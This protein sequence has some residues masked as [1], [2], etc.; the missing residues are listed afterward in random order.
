MYFEILVQIRS[1]TGEALKCLYTILLMAVYWM[2]EALPLPITSMI[3]MVRKSRCKGRLLHLFL[4]GI[5]A[6]GNNVYKG[7]RYKLPEWHQLYG[8]FLR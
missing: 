4:G 7:G 5:A 6:S 1:Q 8:K 3:P 2:T